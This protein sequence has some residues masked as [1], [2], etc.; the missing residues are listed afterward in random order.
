MSEARHCRSK[1]CN[2]D[3]DDMHPKTDPKGVFVRLHALADLV[4]GTAIVSLWMYALDSMPFDVMRRHYA[5]H[6]DDDDP[7]MP[8]DRRGSFA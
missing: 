8:S 7:G 1:V 3:D 5:N 6:V 4:R 2:N